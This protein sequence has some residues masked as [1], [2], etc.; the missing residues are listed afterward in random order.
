MGRKSNHCKL[1]RE[2]IEWIS[3]ELLGDG[4]L[5][6]H[7]CSAQFMYGSKYFEYC[8]YVKNIL[9]AFG[10]IGGKIHKRY[11]KK[12]DC[13]SYH[14][15]SHRYVELLPIRKKWYPEGK[16]IVPRDI[17]LTPLVCRQWYIGDGCL[18]NNNRRSYIK[19][20]T[21]GFT[22]LDVEKLVKQLI[23]LGFK[24]TRQSIHNII[25]ISQD[26]TKEFLKYIGL[27]PVECYQYKWNYQDRRVS[28]C[29]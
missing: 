10:I 25:H 9:E 12:F 24:T 4:S 26:S 22:I 17:K 23:S 16:K 13:Y 5:C 7:P 8:E 27:C 11:H 6:F 1:P 20:Y 2:A 19:L 18:R 3:G 14:Y 29:V 15:N 21:Y 28:V